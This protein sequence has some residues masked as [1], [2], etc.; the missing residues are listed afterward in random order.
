MIDKVLPWLWDCIDWC[1][2]GFRYIYASVGV[3]VISLI[4]IGFLL[5]GLAWTLGFSKATFFKHRGD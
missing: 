2:N 1:F 4:S 5:A 3:D